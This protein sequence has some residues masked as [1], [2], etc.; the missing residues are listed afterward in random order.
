[1]AKEHVH[2]LKGLAC[3]KRVAAASSPA[4]ACKQG[5]AMQHA[6]GCA[7][8][9]FVKTTTLCCINSMCRACL[10]IVVRLLKCVYVCVYV[11]RLVYGGVVAKV[12]TSVLAIAC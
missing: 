2:A 6:R 4:A 11:C 3:R 10:Q 12:R 5:A 1:M 9:Y 8:P 7:R